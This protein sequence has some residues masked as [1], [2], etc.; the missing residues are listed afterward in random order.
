MSNANIILVIWVK[1]HDSVLY[2]FWKAPM[3]NWIA[4]TSRQVELLRS[5][6]NYIF[7][8]MFEELYM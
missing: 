4:F 2:E 5:V 1:G 8:K 7:C 3:Y 6:Y